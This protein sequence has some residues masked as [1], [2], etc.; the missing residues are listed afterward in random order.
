MA[1]SR[2]LMRSGRDLRLRATVKNGFATP[3]LI[4]RFSKSTISAGVSRGGFEP[5]QAR[6]VRPLGAQ[7][8]ELPLRP[9][10]GLAKEQ[11]SRRC[12][13]RRRKIGAVADR[14]NGG[15]H[16]NYC[17]SVRVAFRARVLAVCH[18]K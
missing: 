16:I 4:S 11:E 1:A 7:G 10:T 14:A 9:L 8:F 15:I 12:G 6:L 5:P 18:Q 17:R 3:R 2:S 13:G